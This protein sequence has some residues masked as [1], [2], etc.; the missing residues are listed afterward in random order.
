MSTTKVSDPYK[1][2]IKVDIFLVR[3]KFQFKFSKM[4]ILLI[5]RRCGS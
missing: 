2:G 3:I 4:T 5:G 1:E